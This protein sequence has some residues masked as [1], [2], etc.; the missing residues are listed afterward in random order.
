MVNL[1]FT[2]IIMLHHPWCNHVIK[3]CK[4]II[5]RKPYT[6]GILQECIYEAGFTEK[7]NS[8][9]NLEFT[10]ER[11][12]NENIKRSWKSETSETTFLMNFSSFIAEAAAI[13]SMEKLEEH[14]IQTGCKHDFN[15]ICDIV[16]KRT[17]LIFLN[18]F[19]FSLISGCWLWRWHSRFDVTDPV[20]G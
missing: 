16:F 5:C 6:I 9:N 13:Y 3:F 4:K 10:T 14:G 12:Q 8:N 1:N 2:W 20:T 19:I 18:S 17:Y 7:R 11:K 15:I